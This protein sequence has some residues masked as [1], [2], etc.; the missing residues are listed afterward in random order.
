MYKKKKGQ[1]KHPLQDQ[2]CWFKTQIVFLAGSVKA[3]EMQ[4][5]FHS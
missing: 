2:T 1:Q 4:M 3:L 5:S